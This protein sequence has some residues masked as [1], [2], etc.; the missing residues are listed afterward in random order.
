MQVQ[1]PQG[2]ARTVVRVSLL[3]VAGAR[4]GFP[5]SIKVKVKWQGEDSVFPEDC[6]LPA[7]PRTGPGSGEGSAPL[8]DQV[9]LWSSWGL[10]V[11]PVVKG[12][13]GPGASVLPGWGRA[14]QGTPQPVPGAHPPAAR[15]GRCTG[16]W[17]AVPGS[18]LRAQA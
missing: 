10:R 14:Q 6:T 11:H 1:A 4:P 7:L 17:T 9:S 3:L 16:Q 12:H 8:G 13:M 5:G 2:P 15:W 18:P